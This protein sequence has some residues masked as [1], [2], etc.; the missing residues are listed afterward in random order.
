MCVCQHGNRVERLYSYR[1]HKQ[2][3][4]RKKPLPHVP[5]PCPLPLSPR[6]PS[7][8]VIAELGGQLRQLLLNGVE[9]LL[10]LSLQRDAAQHK[11]A[12]LVLDDAALRG[13]QCGPLRP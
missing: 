5:R 11:V 4:G 10:G 1:A 6:P 13:R 7:P 8:H 2:I 3:G 9:T 12:Q